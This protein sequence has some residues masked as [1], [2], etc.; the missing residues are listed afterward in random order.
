M[1]SRIERYI[2]EN[3]GAL[4]IMFFQ[5]LI[6]ICA[7]LMI[8]DAFTLAEEIAVYAYSTLVIGVVLQLFSYLVHVNEGS[9]VNHKPILEEKVVTRTK[10]ASGAPVLSVV[11]P[12]YN[13]QGTI[14]GSLTGL[15]R[16]LRSLSLNYEIVVV[17]DGST[18]N[19]YELLRKIAADNEG[20]LRIVRMD[21]NRGKGEAFRKG[22]NESRGHYVFLRDADLETPQSLFINY[23]QRIKDADV[24]IASKRHP[25]S[26]VAYGYF[27]SFLS[28]GFNQ[29]VN[30]LFNLGLD[31]TQCGFKLFRREVLN[32][33]MPRLLLKRYAFDVEL[34][35][36]V[37][38]R[39][40]K[41]ITAPIVIR[42]LRERPMK[43]REIFKMALDLFAIFYR[44]HLT[45]SYD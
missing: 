20:K 35:V 30:V 28:R 15:H 11:I 36:N 32:E 29:L 44:L 8:W 41:G 33:I 4:F 42:N 2:R 3:P 16:D 13:E 9:S 40:F 14:V 1:S 5:V 12:A 39:G 18:D 19:T 7:S 17:D 21:R 43:I 26:E 45:K 34:L 25:E 31:D 27:R 38:K 6:V 10:E 22:Y 24:V 23:L 37:K